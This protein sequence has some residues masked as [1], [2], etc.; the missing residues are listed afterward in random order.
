MREETFVFAVVCHFYFIRNVYGVRL[1]DAQR[2]TQQLVA[3]LCRELT[4]IDC[5]LDAVEHFIIVYVYG[6]VLLS[7]Y[8]HRVSVSTLLHWCGMPARCA[9]HHCQGKD[10][11]GCHA[12]QTDTYQNNSYIIDCTV[13]E[14]QRHTFLLDFE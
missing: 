8:I 9:R 4:Q 3:V 1:D 14:E 10:D 12:A 13:R 7:R 6:V 5:V 11:D 2:V